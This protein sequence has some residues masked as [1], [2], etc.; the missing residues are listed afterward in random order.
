MSIQW[1]LIA[2]VMYSELAVTVLLL[3]PVISPTRWHSIFKSR[4]LRSIGNM[5]HIYFKVFLGVLTLFFLD[6]IREMRK[7]STELAEQTRGD[8]GIH[9][10]AEMQA[11]MRLFRA[12]RNF[13]ISGFSL[14]LWVVLLRLTTL[15]SRLA[16]AM[17]EGQ[18]ALKQ[19]QSASAT[20][21]QLLKQDKAE[22][23]ED[24]QKEANVSNEI[25]ELQEEKRHLEAERDA[26][27]KQA[28]AISREYDRMLEEHSKLQ[29][30]L[31]KATNGEESKKDD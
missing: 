30:E 31:K 18:A 19:A 28:K 5:S 2:G 25:K 24:Q 23:E 6:A 15:I 29:A 3:I 17:A 16:V 21:A 22:K 27:L 8:H 26:A 1:T 7:Y 11:H 9:L 13:Y 12:Q 10:D 14:F 20:A 4:F